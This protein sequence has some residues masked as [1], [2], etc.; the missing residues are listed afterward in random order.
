MAEQL[1]LETAAFLD[2]LLG[3]GEGR[4]VQDALV[5]QRVHISD[6]QGVAV[7]A[8]LRTL[9]RGKLLSAGASQEKIRLLLVAPF[10]AHPARELLAGAA[11]RTELRL[12]DAL[13]VEL[14]HQLG[15]PLVTTDSRLAAAWPRSW[16]VTAGRGPASPST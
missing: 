12:G 15:A 14:S 5:G 16:L 4:A 8:A 1:V 11:V 7:A 2:L 13:C 3:T 10:Q 6:H 9:V